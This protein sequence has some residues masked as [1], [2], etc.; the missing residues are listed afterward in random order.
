MDEALPEWTHNGKYYN[1]EPPAA[2]SKHSYG[3]AV[4]ELIHVMEESVKAL[5]V[6]DVPVGVFLSGRV[7]SSIDAAMMHRAGVD[8]IKTFTIGFEGAFA[9]YDVREYAKIIDRHFQTDHQEIVV[10]PSIVSL[11]ENRLIQRFDEPFANT[12]ALI[13]DVLSDFTRSKVTVALSG[14]G[15]GEFFAGYLRYQGMVVLDQLQRVP[16]WMIN[17]TQRPSTRCPKAVVKRRRCP[18]MARRKDY[19]RVAFVAMT[20]V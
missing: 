8:S 1:P 20:T 10:Q 17:T 5:L 11:L 16:G 18:E 19:L 14:V 9:S 3:E 15:A 13:A 6:A 7:D 2:A 12:A 4:E